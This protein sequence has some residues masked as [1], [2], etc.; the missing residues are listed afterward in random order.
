MSLTSFLNQPD[1]KVKFKN[2]FPKPKFTP[3]SKILA[4]LIADRPGLAGT[5]FDYLLRFYLKRAYP[6]AKVSEW[7]AEKSLKLMQA[8]PYFYV[9]VVLDTDKGSIYEDDSFI[10][11]S[12]KIIA[13][14]R[15]NYTR[16]LKT[17]RISNSLLKSCLYLSQLDA[18]YRRDYKDEEIG[19]ISKNCVSDLKK[20]S[21]LLTPDLFPIKKVC[22]LNPSFK[23]AS[24]VGGADA[25]LLIDDLLIDIK[26]VKTLSLQRPYFNQIMGY[27]CLYKLGGIN[28][29]ERNKKH[30]I[31]RLGIYYSRYQYLYTFNVADVI[32]KKGFSSFLKWFKKRA[33]KGD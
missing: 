32:N 2:E 28:G 1:V 9:T 19:Y 30:E 5:A 16:Y 8:K 11:S 23:A 15:E 3:T 17:G 22:V 25:D 7:I 20:L 4:P 29:I 6:K 18:V 13:K 24:M 10:R 14:A 31:K 21:S 27:Y 12:I 26:T 33:L